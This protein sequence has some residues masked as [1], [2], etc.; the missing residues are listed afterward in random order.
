MVAPPKR[1]MFFL[2][3]AIATHEHLLMTC[4]H[5]RSSPHDRANPSSHSRVSDPLLMTAQ[6]D[7]IETQCSPIFQ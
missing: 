3:S 6:T 5:S 2:F 1:S 4:F 7:H